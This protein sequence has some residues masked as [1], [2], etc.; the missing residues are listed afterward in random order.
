M[1]RRAR[2]SLWI[3]SAFAVA[4]S[5]ALAILISRGLGARGIV[6]ALQATARIG[7]L[8][9]W[10]AYSA[11]A[12]LIL[13]GSPFEPVRG[14][15]REL[16]LAFVAV[17]TVHLSLVGLLSA[18]VA[19]PAFRVFVFF[20]GAAIFAYLLALFSFA[21]FREAL[22]VG[23]WRLLS[24]IGMNYLA[25]AFFKDFTNQLPYH[26]L[27]VAAFYLPFLLMAIAAPSLRLAAF[28]VR[29]TRDRHARVRHE[30]RTP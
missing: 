8:L 25:Y 12:L 5:I 4:L 18:L 26:G 28:F 17:L 21:P 15:A 2:D 7:F 30:T 6:T 9:F 13:F 27:K 14:M 23:R 16:G 20:G 3:G 11:S 22:G 1:S 24:A 19:P 29:L 10:P